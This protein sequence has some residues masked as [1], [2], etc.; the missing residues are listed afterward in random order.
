MIQIVGILQSQRLISLSTSFVS[1]EAAHT[2]SVMFCV[3]YANFFSFVILFLIQT[4][5]T[6]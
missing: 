4:D 1:Q 6:N 3:E 2:I 5:I